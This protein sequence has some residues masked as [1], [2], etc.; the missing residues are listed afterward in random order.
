VTLAWLDAVTGS[1]DEK[2]AA[3]IGIQGPGGFDPPPELVDAAAPAVVALVATIVPAVCLLALLA[4]AF[5][6]RRRS[7]PMLVALLAGG[8]LCAVNEPIIDVLGKVYL[9]ERDGVIAFHELGRAVPLWALFFT[10][11]FWGGQVYLFYRLIRSDPTPKRYWQ[12]YG[13]VFLSAI[14]LELPS[15]AFGLY[16]YFGNQPFNPTGYPLWW[17]FV[18]QSGICVAALICRRPDLFAGRRIVLAVIAVPTGELGFMMFS[19][20]PIFLALQSGAGLWVTT[21]AAVASACIAGFAVIQVGTYLVGQ[22][23][24]QAFGL[25]P[26]PDAARP[27]PAQVEV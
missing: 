9:R 6:E 22:G 11:L 10:G 7:G 24:L 2:E 27:A 16:D 12:V 1:L 3:M 14:V 8:T 15:T 17:I 25:R 26:A 23:P 4:Y 18:Y 20:A 21:L 13:G 5:R 19:G